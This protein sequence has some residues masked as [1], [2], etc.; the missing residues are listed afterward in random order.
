LSRKILLL[1]HR[2]AWRY[3]PQNTFA[4]FD[5]AMA[6]GLDGFEFD[7]R[8]TSDRRAV[9]C[10]NPSFNHLNIRRSTWE[11]LRSTCTVA[12]HSLPSLDDLLQR[13]SRKTFLNLEVKIRHIERLVYESFRKNPP[14]RGY[15]I[16]SFFPSV[17]R[18]FHQIDASL[19]LGIV[20]R[21]FWQLR[22][23]DAVPAKYVV[24]R[25]QLLSRRLVE[26]V[27]AAKKLLVTWKVNTRRQ[28]LHAAELGVDG[29]ISA[30]TKLLAETFAV[31]GHEF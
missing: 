18:E 5:L 3:A 25:Y 24:P 22:H 10:H 11:R 6:H 2:G 19:M 28:M 31:S 4:A 26:E 23:W 16:S 17:L 14:Q 30:D 9:I 15:F 12:E 8:A 1:G 27:H 7:I 13:Y 20:A 21:R 29:I